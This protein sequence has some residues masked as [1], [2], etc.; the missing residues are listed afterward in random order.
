MKATVALVQINVQAEKKENIKSVK[1]LL[2]KEKDQNI[3]LII[4]PEMFN[5]PY[6]NKYFTEFAESFPSTTYNFLSE[7]AKRHSSFVIGGSIPEKEGDHIYNTSVIFDRNGKFVTKHRK[8]HLFD[9][10]IKGKI[11]FKES[12]TFSKGNDATVFNADFAKIGVAICYDM[13]FPELVRK[14]TLMGAEIIVI[15]AAFNMV[16]GPAHWH[17]IARARAVDNQVYFIVSSPARYENNIYKAYGH[18]LIIDPWGE[19]VADAG[20]DEKILI[21][22]I[23]L[24]M[25]T[26]IRKQLPLLSHRREEIY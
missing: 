2:A 12:D 19:I 18:S 7:T 20:I 3:D 6:A 23:D 25:V 11:C 9:I 1:K 24:E 14:M 21:K 8:A 22:K 4:L 13:R 15:P 17:L 5:C 16:T 26:K 10:E